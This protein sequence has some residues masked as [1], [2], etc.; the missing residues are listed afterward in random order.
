MALED[1][2]K[3][4]KLSKLGNKSRS[5]ISQSKYAKD[6]FLDRNSTTLAMLAPELVYT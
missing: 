2:L 6:S 3:K 4:E 5:M 1:T